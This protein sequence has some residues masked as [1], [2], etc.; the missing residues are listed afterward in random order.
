MTTAATAFPLIGSQ[1]VGNFFI[2]DNVQRHT[3]GN[4]ISF[5]DPFWGGGE[6]MYVQFPAGAAQAVGTVN[7]YDTV[8]AFLATPV[9]NTANLGKS[10]GFTMNAIPNSAVPVYGWLVISGQFPIWSNASIAAN[11]AV[12]IVAAGQAGANSAG[13]EIVGCRIVKPAT[14]TV[15][16]NNA[17]LFPTTA[18]RLTTPSDGWFVG[19]ALSGTGVGA[20]ATV[21]NIDPDNR[22]L[23]ASV[24]STIAGSASVTGTYN[25]GT[26]FFNVA[27]FDRPTM[28]GAIT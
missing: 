2:P 28:Q 9:A 11:T 19:I 15:I 7:A 14:T 16:K 10:V 18:V 4:V 5:N 22:T 17:Q 1:P 23:V 25:D 27:V 21:T 6:A 3:L 26:N 8:T 24:A 13:K 20:G 12:G